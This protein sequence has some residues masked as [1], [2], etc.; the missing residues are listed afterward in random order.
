MFFT[1]QIKQAVFVILSK[2]RQPTEGI[3]IHY[4]GQY[5]YNLPNLFL[6]EY[7]FSK[8]ASYRRVTNYI[9]VLDSFFV[10]KIN[11]FLIYFL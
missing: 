5:G 4:S 9:G 6:I 1:N 2:H 11:F 8:N 10:G 3:Q 7:G